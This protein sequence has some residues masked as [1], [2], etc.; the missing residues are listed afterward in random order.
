MERS[1][2]FGVVCKQAAALN[3]TISITKEHFVAASE[4]REGC[5]DVSSA[6]SKTTA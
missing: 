6:T 1:K 5:F 3:K 4:K 2:S